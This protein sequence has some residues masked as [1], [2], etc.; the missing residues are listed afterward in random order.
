[1]KI[2]TVNKWM[3]TYTDLTTTLG[4]PPTVGELGFKMGMTRQRAE[5]IAKL[6]NLTMSNGHDV[7]WGPHRRAIEKS[8]QSAYSVVERE[9]GMTPSAHA[10]ADRLGVSRCVVRHYAQCMRLKLIR[11][12]IIPKYRHEIWVAHGKLKRRLGRNP[13]GAELWRRCSVS[14]LARTISIAKTMGLSLIMG[15]RLSPSERGV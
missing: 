8:V 2:E 1:M 14:S 13:S 10:L 6:L 7:R 3:Y 11:S 12:N 15:N 5:R 9:R 4:R